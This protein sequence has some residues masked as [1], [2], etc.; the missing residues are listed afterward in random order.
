MK[1]K[2]MQMD[3]LELYNGQR[4]SLPSKKVTTDYIPNLHISASGKELFAL[5]ESLYCKWLEEQD[6]FSI[7]E[8]AIELCRQAVQ[9]G[10]P[11]AVAKMG[12]YYD[13]DYIDSDRTEEYRC[14]MATDYYAKVVYAE[15]APYVDSGVNPE[16]N[17]E[18]LKKMTA[19]MFLEMLAGSESA[20]LRDIEDNYGYE[21]NKQRILTLFPE[22]TVDE[23]AIVFTRNKDIEKTFQEVLKSCKSNK[24]RAPLFGIL[25]MG[26]QE[27]KNSFSRDGF[28]WQASKHV[29]LWIVGN[30]FLAKAAPT[31]EFENKLSKAL[32]DDG[33]MSS[34]VWVCFFNNNLGGHRFIKEKSRNVICDYFASNGCKI[35]K[36]LI[37]V[38]QLQNRTTLIF[39]DDDVYYHMRNRIDS[40][41]DG[42]KKL[43]DCVIHQK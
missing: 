4:A 30:N 35:F 41:L 20:I 17:W 1:K 2:N 15:K 32:S 33:F 36:E 26:A 10:Y 3:E 31:E 42:A 27:I 34:V 5:S 16:L 18:E 38:V 7:M 12:F 39:S 9:L 6:D 22:L 40:P 24:Y 14:R 43:V 37:N 25:R 19:R 21:W 29:N 13:K 8:R 11:H 23:S 28:A